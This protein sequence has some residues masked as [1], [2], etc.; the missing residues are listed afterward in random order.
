M[1]STNR[2]STQRVPNDFYAT[3]DWLTE[4]IVP[5][6]VK[7]LQHV[8]GHPL[9]VLEPAAGDRRMVNVLKRE[10]G[11]HFPEV[12]MTDYDLA[13]EPSKDFL[14]V[15]P[16]PKFDLIITNPPFLLAREFI[17]QGLRFRRDVSNLDGCK[18][19]VAMILR[20]N[21]LGSKGRAKW[22]RENRPAVYVTPRRP[23]FRADKRTDSIEYAWFL[24]QEPFVET[25]EIGILP[26]E[27]AE[28]RVTKKQ[29]VAAV[30]GLK[31]AGRRMAKK[32][33][34]STVDESTAEG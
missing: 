1:S 4:A 33:A 14:Q 31:K 7:R 32:M 8:K 5:E 16:E 28:P 19:V 22:L 29:L 13:D 2:G 3:P 9:R 30:Q 15:P 23:S 11:N 12:E 17:E 25:S 18:S 20:V 6:L 21:F 26:T 27:D 24:W 10:L 34:S